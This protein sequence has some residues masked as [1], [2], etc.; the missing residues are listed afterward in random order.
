MKSGQPI[1]PH[2]DQTGSYPTQA[3]L[4]PQWS[5][6][7]PQQ[8]NVPGQ[9]TQSLHPN[10]HHPMYNQGTSLRPTLTGFNHPIPSYM[11]SNH[12]TGTAFVVPLSCST[13]ATITNC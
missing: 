5:A 3:V 2:L 10:A 7:G 1:Y 8:V 6:M 9:P 13:I 12:E 4:Y 11:S